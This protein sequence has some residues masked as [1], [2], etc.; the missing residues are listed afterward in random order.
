M[1]A[2]DQGGRAERTGADSEQGSQPRS[3]I[4]LQR[5]AL[6]P[7]SVRPRFHSQPR[8]GAGTCSAASR[9]NVFLARSVTWGQGPRLYDEAASR[10]EGGSDERSVRGWN[11]RETVPEQGSRT[12]R[13]SH[14]ISREAA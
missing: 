7:E 10:R 9:L 5:G 1:E 2:H 12:G 4:G 13:T 8:S 11:G 3:G 6:A 14:M